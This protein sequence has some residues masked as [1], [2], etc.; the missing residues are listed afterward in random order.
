[1]AT[2]PKGFKPFHLKSAEFHLQGHVL[3]WYFLNP[4]TL[5]IICEPIIVLKPYMF[6]V[7]FHVAWC[8]QRNSY[9][10]Q[11]ALNTVD[12][13]S[14]H[15]VDLL[16]AP[17]A[18][19]NSLLDTTKCKGWKMTN[20]CMTHVAL[21]SSIGIKPNICS[22][23]YSKH[24]YIHIQKEWTVIHWTLLLYPIRGCMFYFHLYDCDCIARS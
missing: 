7:C 16:V 14:I 23:W 19:I 18:A 1:M 22:I 10:A 13:L 15:G 4:E 11:G 12:A 9:V 21:H 20:C 5:G 17:F 8:S 6:P 3:P 2:L 24:P